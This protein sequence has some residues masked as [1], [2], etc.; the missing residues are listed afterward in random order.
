MDA[1]IRL[2]NTVLPILYGLAAVAYAA[3]FFRGDALAGR[4]ARRVL[5]VTLALHA[6]YLA[7]RTAHYAHVPLS[8]PAEMLTTVALALALAYAFVERRS[9]VQKTGVFVVSLALLLQVVSSAFVGSVREFPP[10][11]RSPLFA[12]HTVAAVLGYAAFAVSAIYGLLFLVLYHDLRRSRF[13][14]VYDRLPPLEVL[15]AMSLRAVH[16]GVVFL[17][18][19][20]ACGAL[21]AAAEFP[22]FTRDPKFLLTLSVWVVY[23]A[24]LALHRGLRWT[25]RR[26]IHVSLIGFALLVFSLIAARVLFDSFHVFA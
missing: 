21:W 11:L 4:V 26:T 19:T 15:A 16:L 6:A 8:S 13:G 24:A 23:L 12:L 5:H 3:D 25:G 20:I 9:H 17:T 14:I 22:G 1:G 10:L 2:L 7:L 18:L